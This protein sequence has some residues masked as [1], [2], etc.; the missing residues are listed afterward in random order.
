MNKQDIR[1]KIIIIIKDWKSCCKTVRWRLTI[2][3][4]YYQLDNIVSTCT[5][6][7]DIV[8]SSPHCD[9]AHPT[10]IITTINS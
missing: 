9:P 7:V 5:E 3:L 4:I 10:E 8:T 2:G 6:Q 1:K